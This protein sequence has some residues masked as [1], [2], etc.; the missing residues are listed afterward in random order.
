MEIE[1]P[2]PDQAG[3][4]P[5]GKAINNRRSVRDFSPAP[6]DKAQLSQILWAA[7]G[8]TVDGITGPTRAYPSAGAVYPLEIYAVVSG[9]KGISPGVYKYNWRK[10]TISLVK[11]GDLSG[12]L[13]RAA[14]HQKMVEEAPLTLVITAHQG[15]V[16][17]AYGKRGS[18]RYMSMDAGH[19]G[20]NVHLQAESLGLGTVMV[21]AFIDPDVKSIIGSEDETPVYIMP[22]G[23]P[24]G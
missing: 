23:K 3:G 8:K 17:R 22:I 20:Q 15:K 6:L 16:E 14:L 12:A 5:V 4:I 19:M 13:S 7:G 2:E 1:L 21:G 10:N 9:V 11:K 24:A 18:A